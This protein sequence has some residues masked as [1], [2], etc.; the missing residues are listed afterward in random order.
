MASCKSGAGGPG[1]RKKVRAE[2]MPE[3]VSVFDSPRAPKTNSKHLDIEK[4]AIFCRTKPS[5]LDMV[6]FF[7]TTE[8]VLYKFIKRETGMTIT[9]FRD[10]NVVYSR[11]ALIRNALKQS[12]KDNPNPAITIFT[13]KNMAGWT[14]KIAIS[15]DERQP[16]K[17]AYDITAQVREKDET[18]IDTDQPID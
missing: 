12:L 4:I 1:D 3:D 16:F 9:E 10:K 2:K 8:D 13:L 15:N 11:H 6:Y 5:V 14:D 17:L 18:R 7:D